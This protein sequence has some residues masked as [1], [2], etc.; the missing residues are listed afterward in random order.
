MKPVLVRLLL[1]L[2][3]ARWKERYG[4]E[5]SDLLQARRSPSEHSGRRRP[6]SHLGT[7]LSNR[8][9]T[10]DQ[11]DLSL[12][13][14]REA[15]NRFPS[16]GDVVRRSYRRNRHRNRLRHQPSARR[17]NT[18]A[19]LAAAHGRPAAP[20]GVLCSPMVA[21]SSPADR[22]RTGLAGRAILLAALRSSCCTYSRTV[23]P[24]D[25]SPKLSF[26]DIRL[27]RKMTGGGHLSRSATL[28]GRGSCR[29]YFP[30]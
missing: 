8:R 21:A 14:T 17:R 19:P 26:I 9:R 23:R 30:V 5:F 18:G 29:A 10:M 22:L 11:Q 25:R 4:P 3:P 6:V 2:Y 27:C 13:R 24:Q 7:H 16:S 15:A 1:R 28:Q 12:R 20:A